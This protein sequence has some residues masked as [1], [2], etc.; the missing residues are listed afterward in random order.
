EGEV[1]TTAFLIFEE[2]EEILAGQIL[3]ESIEEL[4]VRIVPT[5]RFSSGQE[6]QFTSNLR[7]LVGPA[8]RI[9]LERC[10]SL[11]SLRGEN[12]KFRPVISKLDAIP[13]GI[14]DHSG[15]RALSV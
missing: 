1:I 10:A 3:Q 14:M 9:T 12:G 4:R 2:V 15:F 7:R 5:P 8:M 6:Q 13:S 11:D